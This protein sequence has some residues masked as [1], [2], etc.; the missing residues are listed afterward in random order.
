[1]S[2][3]TKAMVCAGILL[4]ASSSNTFSQST[5]SDT[6]FIGRATVANNCLLTPVTATKE[7]MEIHK[8]ESAFGVGLGTFF[9]GMAGDVLTAGINAIGAAL[10]EASREKGFSVFAS[11]SFRFYD[12]VKFPKGDYSTSK[13]ETRL[14]VGPSSC[15]IF[16]FRA[17]DSKSTN[18]EAEELKALSTSQLLTSGLEQWK[19]KSLFL[20][21]DVYVEAELQTRDDGFLIRPALIWY[22]NALP[23]APKRNLASEIHITFSVPAAPSADSVTGQSFA[24]ARIRLPD[25]AP[26]G[27][28]FANELTRY[29]SAIMPNRPTSG[30]PDTINQAFQTLYANSVASSKTI[31]TLERSLA[32][33]KA[34]AGKPA[35]TTEVKAKVAP[36]EDQLLDARQ[37]DAELAEHRKRV[38]QIPD[39]IQ[40]GSTNVQARFTVIRDANKFGL[41]IAAALK[42]RSAALGQSLTNQLAPVEPGLA[43]TTADTTYVTAMT[44]VEAAQRT[45]DSAQAGGDADVIFQ[46]QIAL[47]LAKAAANAAAAASKRPLPFP[48]L[49]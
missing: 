43:W 40:A 11:T 30:S 48:G 27:I 26:G 20:S 22:R 25:I 19:S 16:S 39:I 4:L 31:R 44:N 12:V 10:E 45:L 28:K 29:T 35:A 2:D 24:I 47:K 38:D 32:A 1:M 18:V 14:G 49:I 46:S 7:S 17:P 5:R 42:A 21:P 9:A 8:G 13:I 23:G 33:A 41:A 36:L 15:L 3:K 37:L 6:E 34:A